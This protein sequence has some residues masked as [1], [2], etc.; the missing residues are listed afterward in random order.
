LQTYGVKGFQILMLNNSTMIIHLQHWV[1][2]TRVV[3]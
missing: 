2:L 1:V 3:R